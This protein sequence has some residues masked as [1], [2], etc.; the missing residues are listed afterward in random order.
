MHDAHVSPRQRT[1]IGIDDDTGQI[2]GARRS[3]N[4][5]C[6]ED[7]ERE[8]RAGDCP[9]TGTKNSHRCSFRRLARRKRTPP[10]DQVS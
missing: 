10:V 8:D 4:T 6:R 9:A 7:E 2:G 1:A 5:D 3:R